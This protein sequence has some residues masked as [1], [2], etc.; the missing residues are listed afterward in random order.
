MPSDA[1]LSPTRPGL[2]ALSS[3]AAA[4]LIGWA[5]STAIALQHGLAPL[6]GGTHAD[7]DSLMRLVQVRDLLGGQGWF[8][9]VQRR[10]DPPAGVAMHWSRLVDAPLAALLAAF[11]LILSPAAAETALLVAWPAL[12]GLA[13]T[14]GAVAC[15][16]RLGGRD[17]AWPAALLAVLAIHLR[18]LLAPGAI[19]HHN[20]QLALAL[21]GAAALLSPGGTRRAG[22]A[23]GLAAAAMLA[24]GLETLPVVAAL[25]AWASLCCAAAPREHRAL[26]GGFGAALAG[27]TAALWLAAGQSAPVCDA[28]SPP[29]LA[30]AVIGGGGLAGLAAWPGFAARP[31]HVRLALTLALGLAAGA[32]A[33][34][35]APQCRFGPYAALDP[36]LAL[37]WLAEIEEAESWARLLAR[38]PG[39]AISLAGAPL[40]ALAICVVFAARER[41]ASR[42]R[43]LL[44]LALLAALTAVAVV[45]VRGA[46]LANA[47]A[48]APAAAAIAAVRR[49][50]AG[51]ADLRAQALLAAVWLA[52]QPLLYEG[53][54]RVIDRLA[55]PPSVAAAALKGAEPGGVAA[56]FR[57]DAFAALAALPPARVLGPPN[58]GPPILAFTRHAALAGPYHRG[59]AG[60]SAA[61]AAFDGA[62]ADAARIARERGLTLVAICAADPADIAAARARPGSL[63]A[64]L[65]A[66]P[67]P[68]WL[69]RL[70]GPEPV[71][72]YRAR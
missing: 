36:A 22:A 44:A 54:G 38:A 48:I 45:Q 11:R 18:T 58:L 40:A 32:T 3:P 69:E 42:A 14:A 29:W 33:L 39:Q 16:T 46:M 30:A 66:G 51:R 63:A 1:A 17:A 55:P 64:A 57:R 27:G 34:A 31:R 67:A 72:L 7:P 5:L 35:L 15:A 4:T 28:L 10:L 47:F 56:C 65:L 21:A 2:A 20:V 9:L 49:R 23:G 12:M 70:P 53:V 37:R 68:D 6:L 41:G 26:A 43:W 50:L 13:I 24:V 59:E 71:R 60:L 61:F 19:D 52:P 62:P 25:A 8:D